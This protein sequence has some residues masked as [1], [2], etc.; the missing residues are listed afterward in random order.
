MRNKRV[1]FFFLLFFVELCRGQNKRRTEVN[2]GVVTDVGIMH[3][4]IEM[5][6]INMSLTDFYFSRPQYQTRLVVNLG[7]SKNDVIGAAAAGTFYSPLSLYFSYIYTY[8][9]IIVCILHMF[10]MA[11]TTKIG[12]TR[13]T[14][15][16][17]TGLSSIYS[18]L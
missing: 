4:D 7:D 16:Y 2:V 12:L 8:V 5:L 10:P 17:L 9:T 1:L 18:H 3:S 11:S 14:H 6:C 15:I 13:N